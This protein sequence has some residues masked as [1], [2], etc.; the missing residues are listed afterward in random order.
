[1]TRYLPII[2]GVLAIVGLTIPQIRMSDRFAGGNFT[3]R[4]TGRIAQKHPN[5]NRRLAGRR[6]EDRR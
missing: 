6:H 4:A 1:M 2:L 5:E 3:R